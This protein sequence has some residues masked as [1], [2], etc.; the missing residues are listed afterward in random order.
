MRW[1]GVSEENE[2]DRLEQKWKT[3]VA[4]LQ[5]SGKKAKKKKKKNFSV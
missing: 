1:V 2:G 3:R 5:Q 4:E